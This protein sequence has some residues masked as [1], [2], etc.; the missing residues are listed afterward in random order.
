MAKRVPTAKAAGRAGG[1]VIVNML[2]EQSRMNFGLYSLCNMKGI[3]KI[4]ATND[5][6]K[7]IRINFSES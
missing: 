2:R 4:V 1:T 6:K 5:M 7:P 3:T